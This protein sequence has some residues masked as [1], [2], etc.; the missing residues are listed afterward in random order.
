MNSLAELGGRKRRQR[1][2]VQRPL[3]TIG[4]HGSWRAALCAFATCLFLGAGQ[5]VLASEPTVALP[6]SLNLDWEPGEALQVGGSAEADARSGSLEPSG[7]FE[8][9]A[10]TSAVHRT[11]LNKSETSG[12]EYSNASP[13]RSWRYFTIQAS[14]SA[15]D[16]LAFRDWGRTFW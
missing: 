7:V 2:V 16:A 15:N 4:K 12:Y 14:A 6:V 9:L 13:T 8:L 11:E 10:P 5:V 3:R 1:R